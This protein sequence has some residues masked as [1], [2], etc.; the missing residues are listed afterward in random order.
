MLIEKTVEKLSDRELL[1]YLFHQ[2]NLILAKLNYAEN[3][4]DTLHSKIDPKFIG[5]GYN[6]DEF[7]D[8][9]DRSETEV[10]KQQL[11]Y[12]ETHCKEFT[13]DELNTFKKE[14]N[15]EPAIFE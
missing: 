6:F 15:R 12:K 14:F 5:E 10:I 8:S 13:T 4:F 1:E 2:N 9:I 7:E 3:Y 11:L